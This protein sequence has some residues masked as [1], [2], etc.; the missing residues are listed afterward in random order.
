MKIS[1]LKN[2][3]VICLLDIIDRGQGPDIE[4][5]VE[6]LIVAIKTTTVEKSHTVIAKE[7]VMVKTEVAITLDTAKQRHVELTMR[8]KVDRDVTPILEA[9]VALRH[10]R[11]K[12]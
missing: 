12:E 5:E 7:A 3:I 6:V 11:W 4:A 10:V 8:E 2:E 1:H 9:E